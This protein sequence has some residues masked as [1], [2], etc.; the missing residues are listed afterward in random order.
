VQCYLVAL[1][2]GSF[3]FRI[4]PRFEDDTFWRLCLPDKL[5]SARG[6]TSKIIWN[7][8]DLI[9]YPN[10]HLIVTLDS[11]RFHPAN[12]NI[13][14]VCGIHTLVLFPNLPKRNG[15]ATMLWGPIHSIPK[16][17]KY[18]FWLTFLLFKTQSQNQSNLLQ[19]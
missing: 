8:T 9:S 4:L 11:W 10:I 16:K 17:R 3:A 13:C 1:K 6:R 12:R 5:H 2:P 14:C 7:L 15:S 19:L 18:W